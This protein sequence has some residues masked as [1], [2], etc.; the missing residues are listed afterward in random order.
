MPGSNANFAPPVITTGALSASRKRPARQPG[1]VAS[2][3]SSLIPEAIRKKFIAGWDSHV[4]LHYLTDKFCGL[5]NGVAARA[6]NDLFTMDGSSGTVVSVA[7]ELPVEPELALTFDEWFQA[8]QRLLELIGEYLPAEYEMWFL[9]YDSILR[10]PSRAAQW[11]LCLAY[12]SRIRR[13]SVVSAVDP[14]QLHLSIWNELETQFIANTAI[15]ALRL[16]LGLAP[17]GGRQGRTRESDQRFQPYQMRSQSSNSPAAN[18][19]SFRTITNPGNNPNRLAI[20]PP[21]SRCFVCGESDPTHSSRR[22]HSRVL[23]SGGEVILAVR[24]Q[25]EPRKDAEGNSLCFPFNGRASCTHGANCERGKHWCSLC[26]LRD[27]SHTAQTC[28]KV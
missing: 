16:D 1:L 18:S 20:M 21:N 22:C 11:S 6:L 10:R 5:N 14:S 28:P 23:V 24:K 15:Q 17:T 25:G 26:G 7:K 19:H 8:W 13:L 12:D 2:S 9:H 4:P 3:A 27:G